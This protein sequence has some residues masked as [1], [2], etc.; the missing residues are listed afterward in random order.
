MARDTRPKFDPAANFY[1][2]R[3]EMVCSGR[4]FA[5]GDLFDKALVPVRRLRQMYEATRVLR[6]E[7]TDKRQARKPE[8]RP[9]EITPVLAPEPKPTRARVRI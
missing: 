3:A 7:P 6:Q 8:A 1:V 5:V 9:T 4:K 2:Q